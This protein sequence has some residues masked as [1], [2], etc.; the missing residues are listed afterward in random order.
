[1]PHSLKTRGITFS[2][3]P[4]RTNNFCFG[5]S[6]VNEEDRSDIDSKRKFHLRVCSRKKSGRSRLI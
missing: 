3:L 4:R 1:M 6:L 5:L 2:G